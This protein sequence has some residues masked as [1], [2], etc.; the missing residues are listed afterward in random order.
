MGGLNASG[1]VAGRDGG[2][3][4]R[5]GDEGREALGAPVDLKAR[6]APPRMAMKRRPMMPKKVV[7]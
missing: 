7:C 5:E 3:G 1:I 2:D 4:A 6:A